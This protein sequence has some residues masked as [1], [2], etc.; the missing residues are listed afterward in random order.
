M[1]RLPLA[2]VWLCG[3]LVAQSTWV[4]DAA[5]G[6]GVHF[7]DLPSAVAAAADGDT[8]LVHAGPL[9]QGADAFTTSKGLTI[10]G[11]GGDVPLYAT[12]GLP[13][14]V[15]NLL[16]GRS[17]RMAGFTRVGD[18]ELNFVLQGCG[19]DVHLENLHARSPG[20]IWPAWPSIQVGMCSTV[21]L[22]DVETFGSP[23]VDVTL[24]QVV[25][26]SCRLGL[27]SI[28]VGGGECVAATLSTVF[29]VE[30]HLAP[31][32]FANAVRLDNA[33]IRIAGDGN[34]LLASGQTAGANV[35]IV[36]TGGSAVVLDPGVPVVTTP[37]GGPIVAGSAIVAI[38]PVA[39]SWLPLPATP[40]QLLT[41]VASAPPGSALFQALGQPSRILP[42]AIG[43]LGIDASALYVF[44]APLLV[45]P[46]G[47]VSNSVM[48]PVGLP[49][50]ATFGTQSVIASPLGISLGLPTAFTVQ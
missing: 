46:S 13:F 16:P 48:V 42:T 40:G 41:I 7:L 10:V 38:V 28:G 49:L 44:F 50:G 22:R 27:T 5:G 2:L 17:F 8:I 36:A 32:W 43:D 14:V 29:A 20:P 47:H 15:Q 24:S 23:A 18:G 4:V 6:P 34:A 26:E 21:T 33:T 35:P 31:V 19:G 11:V 45:P 25:L 30:S 37:P 39:A 1:A 12:H 9:G 3:S